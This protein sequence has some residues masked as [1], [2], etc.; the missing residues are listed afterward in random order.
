RRP[1]GHD[2]RRRRGAGPRPGRGAAVS[3]PAADPVGL[4]E[5][6]AKLRLTRT[7]GSGLTVE[8][9]GVGV[10][11]A[12]AARG[13]GGGVLAGAAGRPLGS[14]VAVPSGAKQ[15]EMGVA[16]PLYGELTDA[17]LLDV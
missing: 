17:M 10:D 8:G 4:A 7:G 13:A 14:S 9:S 5:R 1:G 6:L 15:A 2:P 12:Y 16:E 3:P 11:A